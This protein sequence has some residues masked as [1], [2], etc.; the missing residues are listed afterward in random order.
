MMGIPIP[1]KM[2]FILRWVPWCCGN[3]NIIQLEL[4]LH[5]LY[6]HLVT[7]WVLSNI[8]SKKFRWF[9][10]FF[11]TQSKMAQNIQKVVV[12]VSLKS[13]S[14]IIYLFSN[15][16]RPCWY[17]KEKNVPM[18]QFGCYKEL[19]LR[20]MQS[21]VTRYSWENSH[22]GGQTKIRL[23]PFKRRNITCLYVHCLLKH[24]GEILLCYN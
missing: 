8:S 18:S 10:N 24:Y 5:N 4:V 20:K 16:L 13:K 12:S 7:G 15:L 6:L 2:V 11:S 22:D 14:Y 9:S 3:S 23:W 21:N 17:M 1:R 19:G